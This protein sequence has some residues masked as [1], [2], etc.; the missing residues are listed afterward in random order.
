MYQKEMAD[1]QFQSSI[2]SKTKNSDKNVNEKL[3][4]IRSKPIN[5]LLSDVIKNG[6]D[7]WISEI[8]VIPEHVPRKLNESKI[9]Y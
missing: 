4:N 5:L 9:K 7:F 1:D 8:K 2:K 3:K 6:V